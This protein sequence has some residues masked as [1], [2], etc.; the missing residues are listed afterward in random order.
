MK[1]NKFFAAAF[2]ALALVGFSACGPEEVEELTL[3]DSQIQIEVGATHQLTANIT[4]DA[5]ESSNPAVVTVADGLVTG[6]A[7]GTAI[8]TA[9]A[10]AESKSCV[11]KVTKN[12]GGGQ[13]GDAVKLPY[14]RV[15]AVIMDQVTFDANADIIKGDARVD[16]V[17]NHLY[18]WPDGST[19]AAGDGV[20]K[21]AMGND[22]GY[23]ALTC[24]S[25]ALG[26]SGL[27]VCIEREA[28]VTALE[29][30]R[31]AIL[32]NPDNFFFHLSLKATDNASHKFYVFNDGANGFTIGSTEI[33][34]G[35][36]FGDYLRDGKWHD[37]DVPMSKFTATLGTA[38]KSGDNI[39]CA[40]SGNQ[41]GA[42]LNFDAVYFYEK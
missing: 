14:K 24:T 35:A 22:E 32:A 17:E 39:F 25:A 6:V 20:G 30:L 28:S 11:V 15:W 27:G 16:D 3:S 13:S 26:W 10:G 18:I 34:G 40:L 41:P 36:I 7:E 5:W 4:V 33:D 38:V 19:Y 42:Q 37:I 23:V 21:N 2:A 29:E 1:A 9:K 31:Q 8:V 12:N